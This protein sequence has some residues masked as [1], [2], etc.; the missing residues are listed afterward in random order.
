MT[1]TYYDPKFVT[2]VGREPQIGTSANLLKSYSATYHFLPLF[3]KSAL[4]A[5]RPARQ[6]LA[7]RSAFR[8][9]AYALLATVSLAAFEATFLAFLGRL[10]PKEPLVIFPF[11]LFLSPFPM[12][13]LIG[14]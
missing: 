5:E 1:W 10:F 14:G 3:T 11:L 9:D 6:N 4:K 12:V 7:G 13:V 8:A 2:S